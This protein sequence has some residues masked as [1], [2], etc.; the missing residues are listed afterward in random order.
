MKRFADRLLDG[1]APRERFIIV[2]VLAA[3]LAGLYVLWVQV[4]QRAR[5]EL[6]A[7]VIA[8]RGQARDVAAQSNEIERLRRLPSPSAGQLDLRTLV[9]R[10]AGASGI[11]RGLQRVETPEPGRVQVS[12]GAIAFS[13]W[14]GWVGALQAQ[15]LRIETCRIE[16]MATAGLVNVTAT[17]VRA[18]AR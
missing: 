8:L 4:A 17:L 7:G 11:A 13:D 16:A 18:G 10:Q 5:H 1:R 12:F 15:Q 2:G 9:Q 3:V 14:L 6:S